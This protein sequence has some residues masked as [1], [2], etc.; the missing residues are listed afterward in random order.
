MENIEKEMQT[1]VKIFPIHSYKE[2]ENEINSYLRK[3]GVE[4]VSASS[5]DVHHAIV[6]FKRGGANG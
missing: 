6:V 1:F 2:L 4:L 3:K 5:I